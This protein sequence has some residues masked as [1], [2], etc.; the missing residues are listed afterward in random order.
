MNQ[1]FKQALTKEEACGSKFVVLVSIPHKTR[2]TS[3]SANKK[4][5]NKSFK[6]SI[7]EAAQQREAKEGRPKSYWEPPDTS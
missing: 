7:Q 1:F 3:H 2:E 4:Q 6:K 5:T